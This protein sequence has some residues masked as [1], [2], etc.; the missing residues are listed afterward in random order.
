MSDID[1]RMRRAEKLRRN[2][3]PRIKPVRLPLLKEEKYR[4]V[5]LDPKKVNTESEEDEST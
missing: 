1:T 3:E 2:K 4:R 5:K